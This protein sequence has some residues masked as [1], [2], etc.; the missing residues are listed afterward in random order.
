MIFFSKL[1]FISGYQKDQE[2]LNLKYVIMNV[3]NRFKDFNGNIRWNIDL[4]DVEIYANEEQ[5]TII[6]E[7][8]LENYVRYA[9]SL[10]EINMKEDN[11]LIKIKLFNDGQK[12]EE[13]IF[14]KLFF[15]YEKGSKGQNGLGLA[16]VKR[17]V[18]LYGGKIYAK[19]QKNGIAFYIEIEK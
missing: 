7:N 17:I 2:L 4:E 18:N 8:I 14:N 10:I 11:N 3:Y 9:K 6:F 5:W 15:A 19:N 13:D 1:Q 16:I 12:I